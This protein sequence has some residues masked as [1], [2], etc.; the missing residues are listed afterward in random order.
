MASSARSFVQSG[1]LR[2][3]IMALTGL[4]GSRALPT[5]GPPRSRAEGRLRCQVA[6]GPGRGVLRPRE[7]DD[8]P[9]ISQGWGRSP[10]WGCAPE[11]RTPSSL[12][13][14]LRGAPCCT[15][16]PVQVGPPLL[17]PQGPPK[18][19]VQAFRVRLPEAAL[20]PP[21]SK[22]SSNYPTCWNPHPCVVSSHAVLCGQQNM[23]EVT[24][25]PF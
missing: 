15:T 9:V 11:V 12:R 5:V 24:A 8:L 23:A 22:T 10:H 18:D 1:S 17:L 14:S 20:W 4:T 6:I 21:A 25:C 3:V 13:V 19:R 16:A 2:P 7:H